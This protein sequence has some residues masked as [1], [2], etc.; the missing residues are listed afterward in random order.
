MWLV[1]PLKV[2]D[3]WVELLDWTIE[4]EATMKLDCTIHTHTTYAIQIVGS[5]DNLNFQDDIKN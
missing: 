2:V 5:E 1:G 4:R 3:Y